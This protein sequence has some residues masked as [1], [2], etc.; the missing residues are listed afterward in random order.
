MTATYSEAD[1][2]MRAIV[3]TVWANGVI[4][5]LVGYLPVLY[6]SGI[7][8]ATG[9]D[10][11][12]FWGRW[13]RQTVLEQQSSHRDG[14][15]GRRFR[16]N[17]LVFVQVYG[18]MALATANAKCRTISELVLNSMRGKETSNGVIFRNVRINELA[19]DGKSYRYN[20]IAEYEYDEIA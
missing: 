4:T 9:P 10:V 2:A 12:K 17:G 6:M 11:T 7:E 16:N 20:V 8:P 14:T 5:A 1:D 19:T 13:S 15:N 18:P 3:D